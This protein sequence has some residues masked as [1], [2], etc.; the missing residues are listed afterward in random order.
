[1]PQTIWFWLQ[2]V[3]EA[4]ADVDKLRVQERE[5][6]K[7]AASL[8]A[9]SEAAVAPA[10]VAKQVEKQ[11][12]PLQEAS[13]ALQGV[14]K[15]AK[16]RRSQGLW[17]R[18]R[19][20]EMEPRTLDL[21]DE[22]APALALEILRQRQKQEEDTGRSL[23][24]IAMAVFG[25]FG[26]NGAGD[27]DSGNSSDV[28]WDERWQLLIPGK[29]YGPVGEEQRSKAVRDADKVVKMAGARKHMGW[30]GGAWGGRRSGVL[31]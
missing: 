12:T 27:S 21:P 8:A 2:R 19:V 31:R 16:S 7:K 22:P 15:Q 18:L 30:V 9:Q 23:S 11:A 1:L 29:Y 6:R 14:A 10:A 5:R 17:Y 28:P 4:A 24:S 13:G 20:A 3:D 26:S 25:G